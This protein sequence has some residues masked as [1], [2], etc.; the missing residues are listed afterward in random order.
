[1]PDA[2]EQHPLEAMTGKPED[3]HPERDLGEAADR[4]RRAAAARLDHILLDSRLL[5][6]LRRFQR[7]HLG[8]YSRL[9]RYFGTTH[10]YDPRHP[11]AHDHALYLELQWSDEP[12][13]F[14]AEETPPGCYTVQMQVLGDSSG[15]D[16]IA[17]PSVFLRCTRDD[18]ESDAT[19]LAKTLH[20]AYD[21]AMHGRKRTTQA[22]R[23]PWG[24]ETVYEM[25]ML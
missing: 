9:M 18:W 2:L 19:A 23:A 13:D 4:A 17:F 6:T 12:V 11:S 25:Q 20:L 15:A 7:E 3:D 22:Y 24:I 10:Q 16:S 21:H 8:D 1:M 5:P 14:S